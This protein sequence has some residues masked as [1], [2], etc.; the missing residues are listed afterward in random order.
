MSVRKANVLMSLKMLWKRSKDR[1]INLEKCDNE[2]WDTLVQEEM[3]EEFNEVH[4][5]QDKWSGKP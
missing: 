5:F 1:F 3:K 4:E 2:I